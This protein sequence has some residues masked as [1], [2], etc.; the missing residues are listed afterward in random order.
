MSRVT[1]PAMRSR[2]TGTRPHSSARTRKRRVP[3]RAWRTRVATPAHRACRRAARAPSA[4]PRATLCGHAEAAKVRHDET[5]LHHGSAG[6]GG[7]RVADAEYREQRRALREH[8]RRR[9]KVDG[10]ARRRG[11]EA[12]GGRQLTEQHRDRVA[13]VATAVSD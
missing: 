3:L 6:R 2:M 11:R 4:R 7:R 8:R 1:A 5:E 9:H 10:V 13:A 12:Q